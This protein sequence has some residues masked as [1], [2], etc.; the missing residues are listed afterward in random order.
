MSQ[1][2]APSQQLEW[3]LQG[4]AASAADQAGLFPEECTACG[5]VGGFHVGY[6]AVRNKALELTPEQQSHVEGIRER[7]ENMQ[8]SDS[9]AMFLFPDDSEW[10]EL[11][12]SAQQ[13]LAVFGWEKAI[14]PVNRNG[15]A[16]I[17]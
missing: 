1:D 3:A 14:P 17:D 10:N 8:S 13:C 6:L 16:T 11:R 4:L 12:S 9:L 5:L 15:D 2:K 7:I